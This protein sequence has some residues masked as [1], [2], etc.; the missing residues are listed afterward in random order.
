MRWNDTPL[1]AGDGAGLT[2][3]EHA[4]SGTRATAVYVR[5]VAVL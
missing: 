1:P 3:L 5:P 4:Q 2:I